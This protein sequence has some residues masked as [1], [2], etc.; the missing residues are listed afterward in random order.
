[1]SVLVIRW[2]SCRGRCKGWKWGR[3]KGWISCR[4]RCKLLV[5]SSTFCIRRFAFSTLRIIPR[6]GHCIYIRCKLAPDSS[7]SVFW[8]A[9]YCKKSNCLISI[10][11]FWNCL[12]DHNIFSAISEMSQTYAQHPSKVWEFFWRQGKKTSTVRGFFLL[13]LK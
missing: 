7:K 8:E 11:N 4:G 3:C 12:L 5:I 13:L 9:K 2:I 1:M 6:I 10:T